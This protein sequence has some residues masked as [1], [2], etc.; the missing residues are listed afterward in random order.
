MEKK[1]HYLLTYLLSG[2]E[3]GGGFN[4]FGGKSKEF[5]NLNHKSVFLYIDFQRLC[6]YAKKKKGKATV[7]R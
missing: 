2:G 1:H 4:K 7:I 5:K 3:R 6:V